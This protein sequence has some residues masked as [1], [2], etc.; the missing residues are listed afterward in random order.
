MEP[1]RLATPEEIE[2]IASK[3]DLGPDCRVM[4]F[5]KDLAVIRNC[6]EIDPVHFAE[7]TPDSRKVAF[8]WGLENMMRMVG[9]PHYYFNISPSDERWKAIVEHWGASQISTEPELRFKKVL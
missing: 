1:I 2:A 5:G 3:S 9:V 7:G 4:A 8:L 6:Y